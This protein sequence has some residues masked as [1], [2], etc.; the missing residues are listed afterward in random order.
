MLG[1]KQDV[2]TPDIKAAWK[3]LAR[4]WHPDAC[5]EPDAV[6]QFRAIKEAYEI[7]GDTGKRARYDAGLALEASLRH[8]VSEY[9]SD[10]L[11]SV[12]AA[13]EWAPPLR[14]G[15]VLANGVAKLGRFLVAEIIDW[16]DIT[17]DD[18]AVL[19]SS[20]PNGADTFTEAWII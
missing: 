3:R 5:R 17:R 9:A 19:V 15:Y 13:P 6:S 10:M 12:L 4:Q 14:C 11:V 20:W 18:G 1:L 2:P 8:Q 16:Q 7:L